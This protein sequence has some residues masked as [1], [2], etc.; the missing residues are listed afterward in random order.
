MKSTIFSFKKI[1]ILVVGDRPRGTIKATVCE[2]TLR[3]QNEMA[4]N[5][6][7]KMEKK[8]AN[9]LFEVS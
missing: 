7:D 4:E 8:S 2:V 3:L 6:S 9:S 1:V 5:V